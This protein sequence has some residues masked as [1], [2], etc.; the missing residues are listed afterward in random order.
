MGEMFEREF[1]NS[2]EV[3]PT[4]PRPPEGKLTHNPPWH[5]KHGRFTPDECGPFDAY[6][7]SV[8][9]T[10]GSEVMLA[11]IPE[12]KENAEF[13]CTA[14]NLH[15][16]LVVAL[17]ESVTMTHELRR[18]MDADHWYHDDLRALDEK[19]SA[20]LQEARGERR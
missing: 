6:R 2:M 11:I 13:I 5:Y 4:L 10:D 1:E 19:L 14:V 20:L 9:D 15:A 12:S 8:T 7:L 16:K 3:D 17:E 18:T